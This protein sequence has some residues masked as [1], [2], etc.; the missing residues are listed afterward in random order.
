MRHVLLI[1][2]LS[3]GLLLPASD[4]QI[5]AGEVKEVDIYFIAWR[6]MVNPKPSPDRLRQAPEY[7]LTILSQSDA[8]TLIGH[9]PLGRMTPSTDGPA[10]TRLVI[11]FHL[12]NGKRISF[13]ASSDYLYTEDGKY[14]WR[15]TT[16]FQRLFNLQAID[17]LK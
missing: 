6:A 16:E 7:C 5:P 3:F 4:I 13:H 1:L 9:L 12:R 2:T 15:I 11:D 10:D 14:R 8:K 17:L